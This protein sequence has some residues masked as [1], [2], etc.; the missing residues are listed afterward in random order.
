MLGRQAV[1]SFHFCLLLCEFPQVQFQF[2][3]QPQMM[4]Q[5]HHSPVDGVGG[6]LSGDEPIRG[7]ADAAHKFWSSLSRLFR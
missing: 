7:G 2:P 6:S 1:L 4:N 5:S 3:V